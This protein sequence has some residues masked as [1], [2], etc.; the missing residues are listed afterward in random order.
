MDNRTNKVI[1]KHNNIVEAAPIAYSSNWRYGFIH[2]GAYRGGDYISI[3]EM[4]SGIPM[5]NCLCSSIDDI[6]Y[7]EKEGLIFIKD[8]SDL[9][10]KKFP[11]YDK[12]LIECKEI[13]KECVLLENKKR[14][15]FLE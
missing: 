7:A 15:F 10:V 2:N 5:I 12:L 6:F 13:T 14:S 1:W 8:F 3:L 4:S 11:L 9:I